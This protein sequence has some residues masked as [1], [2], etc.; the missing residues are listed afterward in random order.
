M[1]F[2]SY[3]NFSISTIIWWQAFRSVLAV[4]YMALSS[5]ILIPKSTVL[6]ISTLFSMIF[7]TNL[8]CDW[9][10]VWLESP[11]SIVVC[12]YA[13]CVA[14]KRSVIMSSDIT[15]IS[16]TSSEVIKLESGSSS[17]SNSVIFCLTAISLI[18]AFIFL[19]FSEVWSSELSTYSLNY[20]T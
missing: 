10:S 5:A 16:W 18:L 8:V 20:L 12:I 15:I 14:L 3:I 1:V 2:I 7:S 19:A 4:L 11:I 9:M 13:T 6:K 17:S